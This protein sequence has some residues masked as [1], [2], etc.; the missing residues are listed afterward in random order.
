[1]EDRDGA[2]RRGSAGGIIR[3]IRVR[4]VA[5]RSGTERSVAVWSGA[6]RAESC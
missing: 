1:M 4:G 3:V 6:E 2:E 5:K